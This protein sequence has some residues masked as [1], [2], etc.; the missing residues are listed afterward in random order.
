MATESKAKENIEYQEVIG[1]AKPGSYQPIRFSRVKYK[2][3]T[4]PCI[5]IRRF[6]RGYDEDGAEAFY[7]TKFGFQFLESEFKRVVKQW[8]ILP[9]QYIHQKIMNKAFEL[10]SK[11]QFE[12]AVLQAF[13]CIE[14]AIRDRAKLSPDDVGIKL[15]RKALDPAKGPLTDMSLPMGER[16]AMANYIAGAYGLYKNPCSHRDVKMDFFEAFERVITASNILK[17][18]EGSPINENVS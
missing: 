15:I 16:E 2:D 6:Q 18:V 13:K 1:E 4:S 9:E 7:P 5:D 11:R 12:S 14:I 17:I 3:N 10:L 8:T